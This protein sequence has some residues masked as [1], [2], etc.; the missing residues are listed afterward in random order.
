MVR[1]NSTPECKVDYSPSHKAGY[2]GLSVAS[3]FAVQTKLRPVTG[4]STSIY[5]GTRVACLRRAQ[6]LH[7]L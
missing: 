5:C 2:V 4:H 3:L 7:W 6:A 1:H